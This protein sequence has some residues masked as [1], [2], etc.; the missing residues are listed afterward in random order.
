[1]AGRELILARFERPVFAGVEGRAVDV[2]VVLDWKVSAYRIGTRGKPSAGCGITD[3]GAHRDERACGDLR[4][5]SSDEL[6]V[7]QRGNTTFTTFTTFTGFVRHGA[8]NR[9]AG[10]WGY[11]CRS[12]R[13]DTALLRIKNIG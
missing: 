11:R 12:G 5:H 9:R 8:R 13:R 2:V 6:G 10:R 3:L 1:M 7:C 4:K